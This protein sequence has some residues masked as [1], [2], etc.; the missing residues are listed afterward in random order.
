[1]WIPAQAFVP[2]VTNGCATAVTRELATNDVALNTCAF[3]QTTSE[4]AQFMLRM[5]KAWDEGTFTFDVVWTSASGSGT[6]TWSLS[7]VALSND[8]PLDSAFGTPQEVTD[9]LLLADDT[10]LTAESS[11]I[12]AAG[13][14]AEGDLVVLELTRNISDTLSADAELIGIRVNFTSNA[15]DNS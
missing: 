8:D 11:A 10:H 14:P 15:T 12:T 13:S 3:D 5:P 4:G 2:R 1:M 6:V 7:V 9:T